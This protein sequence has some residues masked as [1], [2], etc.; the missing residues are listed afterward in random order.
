MQNH[1][2]SEDPY[3][4]LLNLGV[5]LGLITFFFHGIVNSFIDQS[6][7]AFLYYTGL[8]TIVVVNQKVKQQIASR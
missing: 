3:L 2:L 5:L 7:M 8:A 4:K 1:F 6:K